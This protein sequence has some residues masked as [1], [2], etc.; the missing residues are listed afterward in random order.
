MK[1]EISIHANIKKPVN[2]VYD[3]VYNP[4]KLSAYFTTG[5]ASAPLDAGRTV[6]WDFVDFPGEFPI[7]ATRSVRNKA[8]T[9]PWPSIAGKQDFKTEFT[10]KSRGANLTRID[11]RET[12]WGKVDQKSINELLSH[13]KGWTQMLCCLKAYVEKKYNLRDRYFK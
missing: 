5:G 7:K 11:P 1:L 3:A 2:Q 9:I 8:I 10:F 13:C 12:G 6:M 4:K